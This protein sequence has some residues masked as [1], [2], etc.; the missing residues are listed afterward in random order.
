MVNNFKL[1][2]KFAQNIYK[3]IIV[4]VKIFPEPSEFYL[5]H[6]LIIV[7]QYYLD[8]VSKS[9]VFVSF[10]THGD[11]RYR[12]YSHRIEKM[13][14]V[15]SGLGARFVLFDQVSLRNLEL[16]QVERQYLF[17]RRGVGYWFWKPV[18]LLSLVER[19]PKSFIVYLDI[20]VDILSMPN[21]NILDLVTES[22]SGLGAYLTTSELV[23][24]T[25]Q[26]LL[27][28]IT[29]KDDSKIFEASVL[30][31]DGSHDA[32]VNT[33]NTWRNEMQIPSNLLDDLF[34]FDRSHR[35]DQTILSIAEKVKNLGIQDIGNDFWIK[36][37]GFISIEKSIDQLLR[38]YRSVFFH[39]MQLFLFWLRFSF[40]LSRRK[41]FFKLFGK[42]GAK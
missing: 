33:L 23:K 39:K 19:Y 35:H 11:L 10:A 36:P 42:F 15:M 24:W 12:D 5:K 32:S 27:R 4:D 31:V 20:D 28:Q 6:C 21:K 2:L 25:K 9:I 8:M 17:L 18:I 13:R 40:Y 22:N 26:S 41:R 7:V 16:T 29:I 3:D 14:N 34:D 30:V 37:E 38:E 1:N